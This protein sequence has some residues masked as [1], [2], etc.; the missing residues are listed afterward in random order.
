[1]HSAGLLDAVNAAR[2]L[3]AHERADR[4]ERV[5]EPHFGR[6]LFLGRNVAREARTRSHTDAERFIADQL[7]ALTAGDANTEDGLTSAS[8]AALR[9]A[10]RALAEA[11]GEEL[12]QGS[13]DD[14]RLRLLLAGGP[15]AAIIAGALV[16]DVLAPVARS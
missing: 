11:I 1:M 10:S 6:V 9:R 13:F 7:E 8:R 4:I 2:A 16:A 5:L 15:G 12:E 3:P 14:A